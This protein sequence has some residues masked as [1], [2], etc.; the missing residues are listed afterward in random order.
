[1]HEMPRAKRLMVLREAFRTL[2]PGGRFIVGEHHI[3]PRHLEMVAQALVF[4]A[5]SEKEERATFKDMIQHGVTNEIN[6]SGFEVVAN[7]R[8]AG[9]LFH[10]IVAVKPERIK[11]S[12]D[13]L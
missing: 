8:M 7:Q 10:L 6:E 4:R 2:K 13:G 12:A 11:P 5:I 3:G 1:L 9:N